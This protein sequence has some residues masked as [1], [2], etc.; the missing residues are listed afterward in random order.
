VIPSILARVFIDGGLATLKAGRSLVGLTAMALFAAACG[1]TAPTGGRL[2]SRPTRPP[3]TPAPS[4]D[5]TPVMDAAGDDQFQITLTLPQAQAMT[6][7]SLLPVA[8]FSYLGPEDSTPIFNGIPLVL[9]RIQA[10]G[11]SRAMETVVEDVC[12][13][14]ELRKGV[15]IRQ[16]FMKSG[17]STDDVTVG[18]DQ[19]WYVQ[20]QLKLPGGRWAISATLDFDLGDC[21]LEHRAIQATVEIEVFR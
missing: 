20:P 1:S 13:R 3:V 2:A 19:A 16:D 12:F 15:I 21:G 18:F 4:L 14:S 5:L 9:W 8:E 10:V 7:T 11:G 17:L 6:T